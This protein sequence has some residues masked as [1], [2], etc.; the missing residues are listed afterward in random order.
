MRSRVRSCR[1]QTRSR[2]R[3]FV[4][5]RG[6]G[7]PVLLITGWTIS[8]AVFD[9]VAELYLAHFRV[10]AY[11]HRGAGRST[12]GW[13]RSRWQCSPPTRRACST[14]EGSPARTSSGCRWAP[15]VALELAIRMPIASRASSWSAAA[16][17]VRPSRGRALRR[18]RRPPS[19]RCCRTAVR[20]RHA[21][22]AAALFSTAS[23]TSIRTRSPP[24]C[25]IS[26]AIARPPG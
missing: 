17:A 14:T 11:D 22:P 7:E 1:L 5:D 3:L 23:G 24:T 18:P 10:V 21:W 16:P 9:P 4:T 12:H 13:R 15:A 19:G 6:A 8:S 25:P 26:L 2:P 20:H